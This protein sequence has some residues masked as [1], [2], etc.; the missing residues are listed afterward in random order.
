MVVLPVMLED[1][2]A[3][4]LLMRR[5]ESAPRL[6]ATQLELAGSLAEVA[7]RALDGDHATGTHR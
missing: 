6:N 2:V 7:A 3:G 5:Q 1:A 4:V